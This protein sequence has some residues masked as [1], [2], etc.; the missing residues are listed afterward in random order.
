MGFDEWA[1]DGDGET[2]KR[3]EKQRQRPP[4]SALA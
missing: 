3:P 4:F 2:R 1:M